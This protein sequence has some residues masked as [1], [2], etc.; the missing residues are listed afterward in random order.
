MTA[1]PAGMA[2]SV[3]TARTSRI[4]CTF[5]N[6]PRLI[7]SLGTVIS[8]AVKRAGLPEKTQEEVA[9]AAV[10]ASREMLIPANGNGSSASKT[11]LIVE[12][13]SDRLE[14]TIESPACARPEGIRKRLEGTPADRV[15]CEGSEGRVRITLA[16]SCN[17]AKSGST[18]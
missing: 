15:R 10:E 6:D 11:R 8:H 12:E 4:D 17:A 18:I 3:P 14:V 9:A 1:E 2:P 5:D 7:V 16:K 13:F